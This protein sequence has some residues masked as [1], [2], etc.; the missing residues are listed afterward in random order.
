MDIVDPEVRDA[1]YETEAVLDQY[2]NHENTPP[3]V[4]KL[5][6]QRFGVSNPSP[7]YIERV[8]SAFHAGSY[9]WTDDSQSI[10]FG[11]G[12]YG[13]LAATAAAIVLEREA[14]YVVLDADPTHGSLREPLLKVVA[15]MRSMEYTSTDYDNLINPV[16]KKSMMETIGQMPY[17]SPDV[18]SFFA[19]DYSPTGAFAQGSLLS[20]EAEALT[21][22][23]TIGLSMGLFSLIRNGMNGIDQGFGENTPKSWRLPGTNGFLDAGNF[24]TSV[25]YLGYSAS[26]SSDS[27]VVVVDELATLIT[28]GR[29]S[30]ENREIIANAYED[31]G[32]ATNAATALRVAQELISTAPEFHS[33]SLNRKITPAQPRQVSPDPTPSTEPYKAIVY[34][35][36]FGGMDSFY[37]LAPHSSCGALYDEYQTARGGATAGL[38]GSSMLPIDASS[39]NQ[40]CNMFGLNDK[41]PILQEIY[42]AGHGSFLANT[43]HLSKPVTKYNYFT[44]TRT[45]LFSHHSMLKEASLVDAFRDEPGTGIFGRMLDVLGEK[46]FSVGAI[47]IDKSSEALSGNPALARATEVIGTGGAKNLYFRRMDPRGAF[48]DSLRATNI[49]L[50]LCEALNGETELNSGLFGDHWSRAFVDSVAKTNSISE[51]TG[52]PHPCCTWPTVPKW[53]HVVHDCNVGVQL[54]QTWSGGTL[55]PRLKEIAKLIASHEARGKNREAFV[56]EV[57]GFDTHSSMRAVHDRLFEDINHGIETFYNE[58]QSEQLIGAYG[59]KTTQGF[60]PNVTFVLAS[61]FARVSPQFISFALSFSLFAA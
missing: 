5:L 53:C 6:I 9:N 55:A 24:N 18:F 1:Y 46:N 36:L 19:P 14:T 60:L 39:S 25:G 29:L 23:T 17:D 30:P 50:P 8:A 48:A 15:F 32:G 54:K 37:M 61:E 11:D 40:P 7:G 31:V 51:Q 33:T 34:V 35:H 59:N 16:L 10:P 47:G 20:P 21:M 57:G 12:K 13:N 27:G 26:D 38:P 58:I 2:M 42:N 3:F 52:I 44:E 22:S 56:V 28:S 41:L 4:S 45:Q 43:G 49:M